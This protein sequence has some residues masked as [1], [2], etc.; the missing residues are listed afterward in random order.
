MGVLAFAPDYFK[1][2]RDHRALCHLETP[3]R[4]DSHES[5][6]AFRTY[7]THAGSRYPSMSSL[8]KLLSEDAIA[9]WQA[10]VGKDEAGRVSRTAAGRGGDLHLMCELFLKGQQADFA[11]HYRTAPPQAK[12]C[13]AAM[14]NALIT[15]VDDLF[16]MECQMYSDRLRLAGTA[17]LIAMYNGKASVI[18]FKTS[19]KP[20]KLEWIE[21]YM[22]QC[23]GYAQMWEERTDGLQKIEQSV[24]LIAND[25]T[26]ELQ[27]FIAPRGQYNKALT[28]L[29]LRFFK[30]HGL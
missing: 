16:G 4:I 17:D 14:R 15:N 6:L 9:K 8:T 22:I 29:R 26:S 20:K 28:D 25:L 27:V 30:R 3:R 18:D 11:N 7:E 12:Q 21:G 23:E 13:W 5:G 19:L 24:V 10:R 2:F 1:E